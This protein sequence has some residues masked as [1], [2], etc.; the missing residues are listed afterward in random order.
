MPGTPPAESIDPSR[1]LTAKQ[2]FDAWLEI[3]LGG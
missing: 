3:D 1:S 2:E